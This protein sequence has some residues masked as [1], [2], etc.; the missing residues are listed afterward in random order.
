MKIL[1]VGYSDSKGGA[2]IAMMRLHQ[3]LVEKN[4]DRLIS[5]VPDIFLLSIDGATKETHKKIRVGSN[6]EKTI[7]GIEKYLI[8]KHEKK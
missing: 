4:I 2:A 5:S 8:V 7:S 3:S 1:H 6:F